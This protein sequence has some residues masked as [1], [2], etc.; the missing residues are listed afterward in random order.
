MPCFRWTDYRSE[1]Y[2]RLPSLRTPA[3]ERIPTDGCFR[4]YRLFFFFSLNFLRLCHGRFSLPDGKNVFYA[5]RPRRRKTN[6]ST[7]NRK[8]NSIFKSGNVYV[9]KNLLFFE[10]L[11]ALE[12]L[13]LYLCLLRSKFLHK[14]VTKMNPISQVRLSILSK[15]FEV[16][17]HART[18][19][20]TAYL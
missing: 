16:L 2:L 9:P 11:T 8:N 4:F 20:Y 3:A 14:H 15:P 5:E 7:N 13:Y 19:H 17:D 6:E 1:Y 18:G 10:N 12:V